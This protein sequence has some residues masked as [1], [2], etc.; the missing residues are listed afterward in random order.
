MT[1]DFNVRS[2]YVQPMFFGDGSGI[3]PGDTVEATLDDVRVRIAVTAVDGE[4]LT[5]TVSELQDDTGK[6][7]AYGA[8]PSAARSRCARST[9]ARAGNPLRL[10]VSSFELTPRLVRQRQSQE[11]IEV[12]ERELVA[13]PVEDHVEGVLGP[14]DLDHRRTYAGAA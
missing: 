13:R 11:T 4:N 1:T 12:I 6:P 3:A 2:K 14:W 7:T 9:C 10:D 5:G 8:S